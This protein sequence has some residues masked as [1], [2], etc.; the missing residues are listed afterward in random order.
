[1]TSATRRDALLLGGILGLAA[2]L[3]GFGIDYG[4]PLPLLNPDEESIV[5]RAWAMTHGGGL[6]PGWYD[7]PS[8]LMHLLAPTQVASAHPSY[9]AARVLVLLVGLAGIG[10]TWWLGR[11]A[12]GRRSALVGAA[13]VAVATTHVAYSRM[14]VTDTLLM[15]GVCATLA[16]LVSGRIAWAGFALGLTASAKY[17]GA[18]LVA[19]LVVASWRSWRSLLGAAGLALAGFAL[20]S[21]FVLVH[22]GAA[23]ADIRRVQR[24][25]Q[26]GWLG[27][28]DDP[29]TPLAFLDRL[30]D[31]LGPLLLIAGI[32]ILVVARRR[33]RTD[34]VL[35]SFVVVYWL[36]LMPLDAHFDR[37]VLPLVPVLGV[38]AGSIR[39]LVPVSLA[40]LLVPLAWSL[41]ETRRLTGAD[42]RLRASAW[43]ESEIPYSDL[44]AADPSTVPLP[45]RN[46]LRL[47][48]PGP[49]R[50]EDPRRSL[51]VLE[52]AG[53]RWVLVTGAVAD[54]VAPH[55]ERYPLAAAF[56]GELARS[57]KLAF[58][59][60]TDD[61]GL[62]G[63]WVRIY[64]LQP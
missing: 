28:E 34:V 19:P 33:S 39:V 35:V 36:S 40:L 52:H 37:Y 61:P 15:L 22:A 17:P 48:L 49:G 7:Y 2:G 56:Y 10:A 54:R 14:A 18:L 41:G 16:L 12:Y 23:W 13:A 59:A 21:P 24:L 44:I 6:D 31:A 62:S 8:F 1:M 29:P 20:M 11:S 55:P 50:S 3:R 42:T 27:F 5:P 57:A 4:L 9:G 43:I 38:L 64:R 45:N 30:W 53:V 25:G 26:A 51:R 60:T 63:P 47:R 32:A 46:A 58:A